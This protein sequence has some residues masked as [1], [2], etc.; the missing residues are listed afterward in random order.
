MY[1]S[2]NL[3]ILAFVGI[4]AASCGGGEAPSTT[5][6]PVDTPGAPAAGK[7]VD[8]STAGAVSGSVQYAGEPGRKVRIRMNADPNCAA[9]HTSRVYAQDLQIGEDGALQNAF[10]W[11]KSGLDDYTFQPPAE[12][13]ALNQRGCVYHSSR[14]GDSGRTGAGSRE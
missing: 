8:R 2:R 3:I 4:V 5:P 13:V 9:K 10:V 6:A 11:I 14:A 12:P 1:C 7:S